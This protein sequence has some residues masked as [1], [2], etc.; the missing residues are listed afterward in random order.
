MGS[1]KIFWSGEAVRARHGASRFDNLER[2]A[3]VR[4]GAQERHVTVQTSCD[5]CV[6]VL[7][8]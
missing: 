7:D 8:G 1:I 2:Y 6:A 5:V 4:G 3:Y